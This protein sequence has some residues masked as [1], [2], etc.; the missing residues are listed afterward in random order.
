MIRSKNVYYRE[1]NESLRKT[2]GEFITQ[3]VTYMFIFGFLILISYMTERD[4]SVNKIE[5]GSAKHAIT[6]KQG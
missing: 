1:A 6:S 2:D 5:N 3:M 4:D